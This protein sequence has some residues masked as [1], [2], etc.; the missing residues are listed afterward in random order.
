MTLQKPCKILGKLVRRMIT[1]ER[2]LLR[3]FFLINAL[4]FEKTVQLINAEASENI[5]D[6]TDYCWEIFTVFLRNVKMCRLCI[7]LHDFK[8]RIFLTLELL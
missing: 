1:F 8:Y 6:H 4:N 2:T 5:I 3:F 7:F